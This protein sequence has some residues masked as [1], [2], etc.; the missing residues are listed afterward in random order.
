VPPPERHAVVQGFAAVLLVCLASMPQDQCT[1]ASAV[2]VRS[3]VVDNE[4]GCVI[5]WQQLIAR[6]TGERAREAPTYLKTVCRRVK[7]T[8]ESPP[9]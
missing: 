2:E 3:A 8:T 4:M 9:R 7:P 1:E 6:A 5:G